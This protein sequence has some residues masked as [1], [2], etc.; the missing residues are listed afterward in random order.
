[1]YLVWVWMHFNVSVIGRHIKIAIV[2]DGF[3]MTNNSILV[4][5][6]FLSLLAW[7]TYVSTYSVVYI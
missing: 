6:T 7:K 1:M 2:P 4:S 3:R 5:T